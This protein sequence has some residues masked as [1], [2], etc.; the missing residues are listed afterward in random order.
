MDVRVRGRMWVGGLRQR[1]DSFKINM[2]IV[3]GPFGRQNA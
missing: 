3:G 1:S 2:K